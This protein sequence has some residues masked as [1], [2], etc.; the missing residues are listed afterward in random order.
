MPGNA[1]GGP[2]TIMCHNTTIDGRSV[3]LYIGGSLDDDIYILGTYKEAL[4]LL[5]PIL[6]GLAAFSGYHLSRRA[7]EP[8]DR[9]TRAALDISISS[10]SA[11]LP[12]PAARDELRS[13]AIAWNQLLGRLQQAVSRLSEFTADAS[14]DL[15]TSITVMLATAEL[16]LRR[17]RSTAEYRKDLQKIVDECRTAST[18]LD[19]LLSL[20][21]S[22]NFVH[23]FAFRRI[24]AAE[25]VVAAC[26]R[27][28]DLAESNGIIL[29]WRLP[30]E[31]PFLDGDELLL[32]RLL[33]ILLDNAIK[34]TPESGEIVVEVCEFHSE[35]V[36]SVRDTGIG[37]SQDVQQQIFRRFYQ[38][39]LRERKKQA[40]NGL[41]LSIARWIAEAHRATLR[42]E[43]A[44]ALGSSFEIRFPSAP[45]PRVPGVTAS[46]ETAAIP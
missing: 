43:S 39:D 10:L 37:M 35:V 15:R 5:L 24:N 9:M 26:R 1:N 23:E 4:L 27:V 28:E 30:D 20:A 7:M 17:E 32:L 13:L 16:S 45:S 42:V 44:P 8:V 33:G 2:V 11:R 21:R 40:G 31:D 36:L 14:H 41:G 34:Y 3:V 12:E 6:V 29:D 19:A 18:L 38:G 46:V 22:D 25:F